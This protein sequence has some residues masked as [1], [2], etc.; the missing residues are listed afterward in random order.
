MGI[1]KNIDNKYII[2]VWVIWPAFSNT[3]YFSS[4]MPYIVFPNG[5]K[6][7]RPLTDEIEQVL[8]ETSNEKVISI[9]NFQK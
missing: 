6:E 2:F 7:H 5:E 1:I 8:D 3:K 4:K 9:G